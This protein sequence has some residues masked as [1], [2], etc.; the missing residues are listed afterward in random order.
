L[1]AGL[2]RDGCIKMKPTRKTVQKVQIQ[3][4][5]YLV[6]LRDANANTPLG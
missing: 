5:F 1:I 3:I 2:S 6:D 4:R